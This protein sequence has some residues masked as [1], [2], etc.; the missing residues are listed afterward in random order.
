MLF[1]FFFWEYTVAKEAT[2]NLSDQDLRDIDEIADTYRGHQLDDT[3]ECLHAARRLVRADY[4]IW[5]VGQRNTRTGES[6]IL[7]FYDSCP[8]TNDPAVRA[9]QR[10]WL[11]IGSEMNIDR[12]GS[13]IFEEMTNRFDHVTLRQSDLTRPSV[14]GLLRHIL[15]TIKGA[16]LFRARQRAG[17]DDFMFTVFRNPH[18]ARKH[19]GFGYGSGIGYHREKGRPP[20]SERDR[21]AAHLLSRKVPWI[22]SIGVSTAFDATR[23]PPDL[24]ILLPFLLRDYSI[25]QIMEIFSVARSTIYNAR[26]PAIAEAMGLKKRDRDAIRE[27]YRP[28]ISHGQAS[29][30]AAEEMEAGL[31]S[32]E[33]RDSATEN[34]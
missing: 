30:T 34:A 10:E 33:D 13:R 21:D 1:T 2:L 6:A 29:L 3:A 25:V 27:F 28:R 16:R 8:H 17:L 24:R 18:N 9:T 20:F 32:I 11:R 23:L 14:I 12:A 4:A 31:N 26:I 5:C 15:D 22:H 7:E 19:E